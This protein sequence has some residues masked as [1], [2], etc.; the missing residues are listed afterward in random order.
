MPRWPS[1]EPFD[2]TPSVYVDVPEEP[3][4]EYDGRLL[5]PHSTITVRENSLIKVNCVLRGVSS[6]VRAVHWYLGD[7]NL[8]GDS[9]LL[10]EYSA[11][12]DIS[13]TISVLTL[14][15]SSQLHSKRLSCQISQLSWSNTATISALLNVLCTYSHRHH[16]TPATTDLSSGSPHR[17]AHLLDHPRTRLRLSNHRGNVCLTSM[18]DR[19][20]PTEFN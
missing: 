16:P 8:T 17:R 15:A 6:S 13:L 7:H 2:L 12:E 19:R 5:P 1:L 18:R 11:E 10:M 14:N 20:Q 4:L 9:K 3:Y